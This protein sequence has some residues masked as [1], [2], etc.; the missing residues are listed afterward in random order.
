MKKCRTKKAFWSTDS[1]QEN[2]QESQNNINIRQQRR[3]KG[4]I[5]KSL[6]YGIESSSDDAQSIPL[7]RLVLQLKKIFFGFPLTCIGTLT[8]SFAKL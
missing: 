5:A 3:G 6:Q 7:Y 2:E 1:Q 4:S 8:E